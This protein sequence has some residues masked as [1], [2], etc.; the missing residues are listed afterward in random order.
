MGNNKQL[1]CSP[2]PPHLLTSTIE[3]RKALKDFVY[4]RVTMI[5]FF[6]SPTQQDPKSVVG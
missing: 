2:P 6:F 1:R 4:F 5:H 3:E